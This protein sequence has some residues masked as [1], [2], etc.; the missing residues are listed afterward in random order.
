MPEAGEISLGSCGAVCISAPILRICLFMNSVNISWAPFFYKALCW[1]A[2]AKVG[3]SACPC[4][5]L[6]FPGEC[7]VGGPGGRK[8]ERINRNLQHCVWLS[9]C[10]Y[11]LWAVSWCGGKN[12]VLRNKCCQRNKPVGG[13][14]RSPCKVEENYSRQTQ[15]PVH[16]ALGVN[17][18][19]KFD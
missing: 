1:E 15:I 14:E 12:R 3:D 18:E 7:G 6:Q 5:S 2:V 11:L 16:R 13:W 10:A 19:E 9:V 4:E 8:T 17:V